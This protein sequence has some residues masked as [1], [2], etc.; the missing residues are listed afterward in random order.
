MSHL[1]ER[2]S[3]MLK[4]GDYNILK[5]V[6]FVEFGA[7]LQDPDSEE[8]ILLPKKFVTEDMK[9]DDE[10]EVFVYLDS[11]DR[12]I[13]T[14]LR[15]FGR[16]NEIVNLLCVGNSSI[17]AFLDW[18][19]E[20][21]LFVPFKHQQQRMRQHEHYVVK[22]LFDEVSGRLLG[23]NA[24]G[25]I[26]H[27]DT[28]KVK[29]NECMDLVIIGENDRGYQAVA[30][31][32]YMGILYKNQVFCDLKTGDIVKGYVLKV[33]EDGKIDFTLQ[34]PGFDGVA[35]QKEK[36]FEQLASSPDG[37]T[38]VSSKTPPDEIY[39]LFNMSKKTFKQIIGMLYKERRITV[40]D[41]FI[42]V[43]KQK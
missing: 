18:G 15:P 20:K 9:K 13:A 42:E 17:G 43:V 25:R 23:S 30:N 5:A 16:V 8:T 14:T 11:E 31:G 33:R 4:I 2:K 10:I 26:L 32:E 12:K 6:K 34:K 22:I 3:E 29:P 41:D 7:Y 27:G 39:A 28:K 40:S 1:S 35:M 19:L 38:F 36:V 24:F 37:K 21:D